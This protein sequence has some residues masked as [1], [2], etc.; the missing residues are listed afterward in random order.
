MC[1]T[2]FSIPSSQPLSLPCSE[3]MRFDRGDGEGLGNECRVSF[4]FG[5]VMKISYSKLIPSDI[6]AFFNIDGRSVLDFFHVLIGIFVFLFYYANS[7]CHR[8]I[9][10]EIKTVVAALPPSVPNPTPLI[11]GPTQFSIHTSSPICWRVTSLHSGGRGMAYSLSSSSSLLFNAMELEE[12]GGEVKVCV[13]GGEWDGFEEGDYSFEVT[14]KSALYETMGMGRYSFS[15]TQGPSSSPMG[16]QEVIW[17]IQFSGCSSLWDTS[18]SSIYG[19]FQ[20]LLSLVPLFFSS[21]FC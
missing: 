21:F 16:R 14:G 13:E 4:L 15:I 7:R 1:F 12:E 18:S 5:G 10:P 9:K 2:G 19:I 8:E 20:F 11:S 3:F 6:V 17:T